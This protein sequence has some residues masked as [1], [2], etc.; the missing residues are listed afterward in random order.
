MFIVMSHRNCS[1]RNALRRDFTTGLRFLR[2]TAKSAR[3]KSISTNIRL[4]V[5]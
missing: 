4:I 2:T 1:A 3:R 5:K